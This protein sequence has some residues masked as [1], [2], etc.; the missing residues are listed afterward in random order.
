[1]LPPPHELMGMVKMK[2]VALL[3]A[4]MTSA[5]LACTTAVLTAGPGAEQTT[6]VTLVGTGDIAPCSY[7]LDKATANL[8]ANV[9]RTVFTLGDN[10]YPDGTATQF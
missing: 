6:T 8:L 5:L 2:K 9:S 7:D 1:M 3:L 4:S 10:V